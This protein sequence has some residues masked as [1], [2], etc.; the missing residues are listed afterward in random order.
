MQSTVHSSH[1][2]ETNVADGFLCNQQF[3][4]LIPIDETSKIQG[5]N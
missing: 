5:V 3:T 1:S 4:V 2:K